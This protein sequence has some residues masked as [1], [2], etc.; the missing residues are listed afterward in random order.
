MDVAA[1]I[2]TADTLPVP[3]GWF[4][5]LLL[6][7][8]LLHL[9]FM[10]A[11][12]GSAI[13]GL[14]SELRKPSEPPPLARDLAG[15][16]PFLIAFAVNFGVAPLLFLQV[17]YGHFMYTSSVL[18][19]VY[20]LSVVGA[21][22]LVY[23]STYYRRIRYDD[24]GGK[25]VRFLG[26]AVFLLLAIGFIFSNN[27][28][29]MLRP[30]AWTGYFTHRGGT[31]LNL[32]DPTLIPRW[33]HF[34]TASVA[35]GGLFVALVGRW[36]NDTGRVT[37]GLRWF[38]Y[39][40]LVQ[41]TVGLVFLISLPDSIRILFLGDSTLHTSLL[42]AGVVLA[43]AAVGLAMADLLWPCVAAAGLTVSIMILMRDLLRR[44]FLA[45]YFAPTD[46]EVV[47]QYSP[48][49]VFFLSLVIGLGIVGYMLVLAARA[50]RE[51]RS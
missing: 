1:L 9:L 2:P 4:Q 28:T 37:T 24:L 38:T 36:R 3:W 47:P 48:M 22:I 14:V 39:A 31:L 7:T 42:L 20:W 34:M 19:A 41:I 11:M 10:N 35:V 21:L 26:L 23:A 18:M 29:L 8:F 12:L 17:L 25:R 16:L 43:L 33:L 50:V 6:L 44:A 51:V 49:I 32:S 45:P 5:F 13:I 30:E 27:M 15:S 40:T 46:L